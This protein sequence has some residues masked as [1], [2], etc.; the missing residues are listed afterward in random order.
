MGKANVSCDVPF[1]SGRNLRRGLRSPGPTLRTQLRLDT[2]G[3]RSIPG[4]ILSHQIAHLRCWECVGGEGRG[5]AG[6]EFLCVVARPT[7]LEPHALLNI[8]T[9]CLR[10]FLVSLGVAKRR[11]VA[12]SHILLLGNRVPAAVVAAVV[13]A[14]GELMHF[15]V[16]ATTA[17]TMATMV[18]ARP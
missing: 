12:P 17:T 14:A 1:L 13:A 3:A 10:E 8:Y 6:G 11:G 18:T 15:P 4:P 16:A 2:L 7:P 5:D 9:S